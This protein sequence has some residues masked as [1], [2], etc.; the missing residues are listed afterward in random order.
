MFARRYAKH[1]MR[2]GKGS[3]S[4]EEAIAKVDQLKGPQSKQVSRHIFTLARL[5]FGWAHGNIMR[6]S[7]TKQRR[8][9]FP[10]L[11]SSLRAQVLTRHIPIHLPTSL[12][13]FYF[14]S[15][16][17]RQIFKGDLDLKSLNLDISA[18]SGTFGIA[19]S[20]VASPTKSSLPGDGGG[21][22][23]AERQTVSIDLQQAATPPR[24]T[25]RKDNATPPSPEAAGGGVSFRG[26]PSPAAML[27]EKSSPQQQPLLLP[28]T[29]SPPGGGGESLAQ[30]STSLG[31]LPRIVTEGRLGAGVKA[32]AGEGTG[33][34]HKTAASS[35]QSNPSAGHVVLDGSASL[36]SAEG[37]QLPQFVPSLAGGGRGEEGGGGGLGSGGGASTVSNTPSVSLAMEMVGS[38]RAGVADSVQPGVGIC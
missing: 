35:L 14:Q 28:D 2:G 23:G 13:L 6:V 17:I 11:P 12:P 5:A 7:C 26:P 20:P 8:A 32:G 24:Q 10:P 9:N 4:N 31:N 3:T 27:R 16:I 19:P 37:S 38:Q 22:G 33:G 15:K 29:N 18:M 21:G 36:P 30:F 34:S 1:I 25:R